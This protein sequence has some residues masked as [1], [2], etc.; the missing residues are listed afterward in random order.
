MLPWLS[1]DVF[2]YL[3][4]G[5]ELINGINPYSIA[6]D[7]PAISYLQNDA[8]AQMAFQKYPAIYPPFSIYFF[9]LANSIG[10]IFSTDWKS[11]FFGWKFILFAHEFAALAI[12]LFSR[13]KK[14][15]SVKYILAY[16]IMP[17]PIVEII[18]QGHCDGLAVP[19]IALFILL[20]S[21]FFHDD[22]APELKTNITAFLLGGAAGILAA[23]KL[24][25]AVLFGSIFATRKP[26]FSMRNIL[27]ATIGAIIFSLIFSLPLLHDK[28]T[29]GNFLSVLN[30]YNNTYFNS[31]PLMFLR[32]VAELFNVP[33]WW[34]L[35]P[36][37]LS[38]IRGT[39]LIILIFFLRPSNFRDTI[40]A[41]SLILTA[42]TV[43][44]PKVHAWYFVP[45]LF[46]T[47]LTRQRWIVVFAYSSAASYLMYG[48]SA[49]KELFVLEYCVWTVA[50]LYAAYDIRKNG[51]LSR[52][53][54]QYSNA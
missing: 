21:S 34:L 35:A 12:L 23:V 18:G 51:I 22:S 26:S 13:L 46:L 32:Y 4:Y 54:V 10:S 15:V 11:A 52:L 17:L 7:S 38:L 49:Q 30:F 53:D 6:A 14:Y 25:P 44:S 47:V 2:G 28:I 39:V 48:F 31:P 29:A 45:V 5:R 33:D 1:D 20:L 36:K 9:G 43:I 16:L 19:Y 40:A 42:A 8:Y 50:M 24:I 41:G 27:S 3:F 37:I